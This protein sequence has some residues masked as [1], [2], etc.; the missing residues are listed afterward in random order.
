MR[1]SAIQM[2][3]GADPAR[4]LE[5]ADRLVRDT[6]RAGAELVV[7]PEKWTVLGTAADFRAGARDL[8]RVADV[9]GRLTALEHRWPGVYGWDLS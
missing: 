7:L 8:A 6:V 4:N 3:A 5:R 1:V 9:R 2:N